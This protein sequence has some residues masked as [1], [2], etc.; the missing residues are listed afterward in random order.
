M[1]SYITGDVTCPQGDGLKILIHIVNNL[2]GWGRGVVVAISRRWVKPEQS[3]RLWHAKDDNFTLGMVQLVRVQDD[4]IVANMVAQNGYSYKDNPAID[5]NALR[6]CLSKVAK[7]AKELGAKIIAPRLGCGLAC[8]TW[9][10]VE[11]ILQETMDDL[12]VT[13]YD[14]PTKENI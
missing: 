14:L 6:T 1:I 4:L 2:G 12:D 10:E 9:T 8:G 5:Y 13:V 11:Q 7:R 3:Y